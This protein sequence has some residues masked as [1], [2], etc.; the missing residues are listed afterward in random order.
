[1]SA[2]NESIMQRTTLGQLV[3]HYGWD[4]VPSFA[5]SVTITSLAS[6]VESVSPGALV[7]FGDDID[8]DKLHRARARGAYAALV[9]PSARESL[10]S[11]ADLPLLFANPTPQQLGLLTSRMA[12]IPPP[13]WRCSRSAAARHGRTPRSSPS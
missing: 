13:C 2:V 10:L 8:A 9:P 12:A 6:D 4:L 3:E 7:I 11:E 1:M 5:S